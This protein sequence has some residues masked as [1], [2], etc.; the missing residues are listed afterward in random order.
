MPDL[1]PNST[2]AHY[3]ILSRLGAGG[4]GEVY[5]AEDTQL[6][7][8]VAL[9]ILPEDVVGDRDRERRFVHEARAA[10]ALNHSNIAHIYQVGESDGLHFIAMEYVE[11]TP[12]NLKIN[13]HPLPV[14]EIVALACQIA[15]ALEEAHSK[16]IVHRDIKP[17]NIMVTPRGDAKLLDFGLAK[18][19]TEVVEHHSSEAS[20]ELLTTPGI[21]MGTVM[22]MSPEQALGQSMDSRSDIFSFGAVLYEMTTGRLAFSGQTTTETIDRIGHSQPE[23]VSRFNPSAPAELERMIRKC[24]EKDKERRYQTAHELL[25]DLQNLKRDTTDVTEP[26]FVTG[27]T[28]KRTRRPVALIGMVLIIVVGLITVYFYNYRNRDAGPTAIESIAVLPLVNASGDPNMEY[29]SDGI[30]ESIINSLSQVPDLRVTPRV[31][32]FRYKGRG[33]DLQEIARAL[34]VRSILTGKVSQIG[35]TLSIQTDLIDTSKQTQLWGQKYN[36]K[37]S[38]VLTLEGD[39]AD[40]IARKLAVKLTGDTKTQLTKQYTQDVEAYQLYLKGRYNWKK[41]TKDALEQSVSYFQQAIERDPRY[42]LAYSGL[43]D[44]YA[45]LGYMYRPPK[46]VFPK[47]KTAAE[48]ALRIDDNL[49]AGHISLAVCKLL[50][51]WDWA[52]AQREAQR[53]KELDASYARAIEINTNYED[54]HH[55]Y[56]QALDTLGKPEESIAEMQRALELD[57]LSLPINIEMGW[58]LYIARKYDEAITQCRKA[59]ELDPTFVSS[60][61]C[62]SQSYVQKRLYKEAIETM[63][64]ARQMAGDDSGVLMELGYAYAFNGQKDQALKIVDTLKEKS[65]HEYVDPACIALVYVAL[66]QKDEG[67]NW[68]SKAFD[69][70]SP[71]MTWLKVEPKFDPVRS[72]ERFTDLMKRVGIS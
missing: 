8:R 49:A 33:T 36:R 68:L 31:A 19:K 39:I 59:F 48:A 58:S 66:G 12:L 67:L 47:A 61:A 72:D 18:I 22:Y 60:Y 20:T 37:A 50:Y 52:G 17:A 2:L 46:E 40:E 5:L 56:C 7:R 45:V 57:P 13:G 30:T 64:K 28:S 70:R 27:V 6:N 21:V 3:T 15:A 26:R 38:D 10:A 4:M 53:A 34:G 42:A 23:A 63:L 65:T 69:A 35:D 16:G 54:D 9:K 1:S 43:A 55:F 62:L 14:D 32:V 51:D 41:Y 71:W 25:V 11:G 24:L 44:A 29:L